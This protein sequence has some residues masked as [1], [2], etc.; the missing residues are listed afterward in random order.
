MLSGI[1]LPNDP[2]RRKIADSD[3]YPCRAKQLL[4]G[5]RE[6]SQACHKNKRIRSPESDPPESTEARKDASFTACC[7]LSASK[8]AGQAAATGAKIRASV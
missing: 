1:F 8:A 4:A 5:G 6:R 7:R 2:L 3:A